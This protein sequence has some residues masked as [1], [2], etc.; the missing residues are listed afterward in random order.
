MH[1]GFFAHGD[2]RAVLG[3]VV[4]QR[5]VAECMQSED[6]TAIFTM[7]RLQCRL[8]DT[9]FAKSLGADGN[10]RQLQHAE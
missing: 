6:C 5:E 2:G 4:R 10:S 9:A 1:E 7:P 3:A 8:P